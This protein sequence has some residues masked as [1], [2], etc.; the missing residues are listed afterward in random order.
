MR[1]WIIL[2]SLNYR[3]RKKIKNNMDNIMVSPYISLKEY[4]CNCCG[5]LPPSFDI[6]NP[7]PIFL[8]L[9]DDFS[10]IREAFGKPIPVSGYRCKRHNKAIGGSYLSAHMFGVALDCKTGSQAESERFAAIVEEKCP[11]LRMGVYKTWCHIDNAYRIFPRASTHWRKGA[12][13][14]E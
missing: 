5:K 13:W 4:Q 3:R 8:E 10:I 9:F 2:R 12:R 1:T 11:E 6:D 7:N 14:A